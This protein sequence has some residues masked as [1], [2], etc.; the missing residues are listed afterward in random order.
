MCECKCVKGIGECCNSCSP[1]KVE[2]KMPNTNDFSVAEEGEKV[3]AVNKG[4]G[5]VKG[6]RKSR[7]VERVFVDVEF[8]R[9]NGTA[10]V[11]SFLS[12]GMFNFGDTVQSLFWSEP[13][14]SSPVRKAP[15]PKLKVDQRVRVWDHDLDKSINRHFSHFDDLGIIRVWQNGGTSFTSSVTLGYLNWEIVEDKE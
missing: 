7:A 3:W 12:D 5:I 4:V 10:Y 9:G 8:I 15:L 11:A 1:A 13:S 6:V 2:L 14:I